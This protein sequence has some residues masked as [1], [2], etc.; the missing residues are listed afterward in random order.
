MNEPWLDVQRRNLLAEIML[1]VYKM[2]SRDKPTTSERGGGSVLYI[3][4]ILHP[5]LRAALATASCEILKAEIKVANA[6]LKLALVYHI[7]H[8]LAKQDVQ[9][10]EKLEEIVSNNH[11]TIIFGDFN[12]HYIDWVSLTS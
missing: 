12:L 5:F 6:I 1:P 3:K 11:E 2:F 8:T 10:Y 9:L 4:E 7:S